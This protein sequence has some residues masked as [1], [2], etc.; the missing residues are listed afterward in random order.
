MNT[1]TAGVGTLPSVLTG[2]SNRL[3]SF[4]STWVWR[5]MLFPP[6]WWEGFGVV[7]FSPVWRGGG[8]AVV[9]GG[10]GLVIP[11][12]E[13]L[14]TRSSQVSYWTKSLNINQTPPK[15]AFQ[16]IQSVPRR[17]SVTYCCSPPFSTSRV[18]CCRG[19]L[20]GPLA[21]AFSLSHS[22][23]GLLPDDFAEIQLC[24]CLP[25]V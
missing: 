19:F 4:L 14:A 7:E 6:W 12:C 25:P 17:L 16:A 11:S 9:A 2:S 13:K 8:R 18:G 10:E 15:P 20:T 1:N 23:Q 5:R 3:P 21:F 22:T 24:S